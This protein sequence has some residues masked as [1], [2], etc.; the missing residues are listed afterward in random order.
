[1]SPIGSAISP[2][3]RHPARFAIKHHRRDV[4]EFDLA[5]AELAQTKAQLAKTGLTE[6]SERASR[7]VELPG[8]RALIEGRDEFQAIRWAMLDL[9]DGHTGVPADAI[10][11]FGT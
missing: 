11:T 1:M 6:E 10:E 8:K 3:K 9:T 4:R 5:Y 7:T 2:K